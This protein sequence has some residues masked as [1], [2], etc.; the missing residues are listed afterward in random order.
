[1]G[2]EWRKSKKDGINGEEVGARLRWAAALSAFPDIN[3]KQTYLS[4]SWFG[5]IGLLHKPCFIHH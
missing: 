5:K 4:G 2:E 3:L 1:M